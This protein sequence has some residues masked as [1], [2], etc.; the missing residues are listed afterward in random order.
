MGCFVFFN[1][2][3]LIMDTLE[4][5]GKHTEHRLTV[6]EQKCQ[7]LEDSL[8]EI[9]GKIDEILNNHLKHIQDSLNTLDECFSKKFISVERFKPVEKIVYG[10]IGVILTAVLIAIITLIIEKK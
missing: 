7:M 10:A 6:V 5:N 3:N 4:T 1:K 9:N 2:L 8:E